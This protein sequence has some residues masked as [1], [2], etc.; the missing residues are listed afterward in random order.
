MGRLYMAL[1]CTAALCEHD[2]DLQLDEEML[3]EE[4]LGGDESGQQ[5]TSKFKEKQEV[6]LIDYKRA[7]TA[8]IALAG[9]HFSPEA[10]RAKLLSLD[11]ERLSTDQL[12]SLLE[13]LPTA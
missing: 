8:G 6:V 7:Q 13:F 11:D 10:L 5:G 4:V 3:L 1:S 2:M 12:K 9:I